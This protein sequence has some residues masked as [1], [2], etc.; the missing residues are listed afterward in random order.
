MNVHT[1]CP[2]AQE[3]SAEVFEMPEI[4]EALGEYQKLFEEVSRFTGMP[5]KTTDDIQ[6]LHGTLLAE[7]E[8]GLKLPKWTKKYYPEKLTKLAELSYVYSI[9]TDELKR[10]K[11]GPFIKKMIDQYEQKRN[12]TLKD[13]KISLYSA[14]DTS[15]AYLLSGLNVWEKQYPTYGIMAMFELVRDKE[16][17]EI[18]VQIYLRKSPRAGAVP[19]TIPGCDHFCPLD[20]FVEL[21]RD[22]VSE[23]YEALCKP[24]NKD[25]VAPSFTSGFKG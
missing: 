3:A 21:T 12:G 11:A 16:T 4:K 15:V 20:K 8:Y 13:L 6:W 10:L 5:M 19:L 14:H 23:D 9:Y 24:K 25:Y 1:P 7:E 18:G 17:G 22:V 2:R